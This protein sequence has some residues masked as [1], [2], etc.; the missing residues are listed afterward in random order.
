MRKFRMKHYFP[1]D[2]GA[3]SPGK[4]FPVL[5]GDMDL[6]PDCRGPDR[7]MKLGAPRKEFMPKL[8]RFV[9]CREINIVKKLL[10]KGTGVN[11]C[12][13]LDESA[14]GAAVENLHVD[15]GPTSWDVELF[16]LPARQEHKEEA[17]NKRTDKKKLLPITSAAG[18][19]RPEEV[20]QWRKMEADPKR[21]DPDDP[22]IVN[23]DLIRNTAQPEYHSR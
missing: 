16:D 1:C 9:P 14:I 7:I 6:N 15:N 20:E 5:L 2:E 18:T 3:F 17:L 10:D 21:R 19:G 8:I 22:A 12:S 23:L 13:E 4:S 11:L